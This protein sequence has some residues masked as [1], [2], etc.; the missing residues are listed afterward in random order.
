MLVGNGVCR[1]LCHQAG[2]EKTNARANDKGVARMKADGLP[3][4]ARNDGVGR[5]HND[6]TLA[7]ASLPSP[8]WREMDGDSVATN[9]W[10]N[11][12]HP[13]SVFGTFSSGG[14][15]GRRGGRSAG[16]G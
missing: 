3:R 7:R 13:S 12:S 5:G 15:K 4:C 8:A 9:A 16:T 14:E 1:Y 11:S 6:E 2:E 10:V